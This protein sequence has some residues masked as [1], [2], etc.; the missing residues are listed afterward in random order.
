MGKKIFKKTSSYPSAVEMKTFCES[1]DEDALAKCMESREF[2]NAVS[3]NLHKAAIL[4]HQILAA[5]N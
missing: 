1:F 2:L 4:A 5:E 3:E